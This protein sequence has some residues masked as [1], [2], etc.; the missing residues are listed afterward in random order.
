MKFTVVNAPVADQQLA[1]LWV[2]ATD[3]QSVADAFN[4][5]ESSLKNNAHLQGRLHPNGWRVMIV[6]PLAV[7][8]RVSE[9]DR[10]VTI[11]SVARR[12]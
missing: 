8:F 11:I 1:E 7:A 4:R 3:R 10:L 12:A 5:I 2:E 6:P 9:E